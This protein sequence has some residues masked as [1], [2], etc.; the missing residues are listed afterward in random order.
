MYKT[1]LGRPAST[2]S[3]NR[4]FFTDV[5]P[6][7]KKPIYWKHFAAIQPETPRHPGLALAGKIL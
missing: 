1:D 3:A 5:A 2:I 6:G 4:K 7:G